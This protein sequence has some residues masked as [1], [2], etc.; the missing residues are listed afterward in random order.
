MRNVNAT[1]LGLI[2]A[3]TILMAPALATT[4]VPETAAPQQTGEKSASSP[5]VSYQQKSDGTW[6][7][8]ACQEVGA[9][10]QP[11]PRPVVHSNATH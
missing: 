10:A 5:C 4:T 8:L 7:A 11:Q 3:L 1:L 6:A 9:P 2:A